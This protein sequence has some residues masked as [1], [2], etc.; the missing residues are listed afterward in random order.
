MSNLFLKINYLWSLNILEEED[1]FTKVLK[2][3]E[4]ERNTND[5][6]DYRHQLEVI[7]WK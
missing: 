2:E 5:W 4:E 1:G 6:V 7:E 3:E